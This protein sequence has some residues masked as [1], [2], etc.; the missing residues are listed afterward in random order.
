[1]SR[2]IGPFPRWWYAGTWIFALGLMMSSTL[3]LHAQENRRG[4]AIGKLADELVEALGR[5][6]PDQKNTSVAVR[7]L[8]WDPERLSRLPDDILND[9]DSELF[10]LLRQ[11]F[12]NTPMEV[13]TRRNLMNVYGTRREHRGVANYEQELLEAGADVEVYCTASWTVHDMQNIQLDCQAV[14]LQQRL[15][16]AI[17][18]TATNRATA[19]NSVPIQ[20]HEVFDVV[21]ADLA[22]EIV[23]QLAYSE[24]DLRAVEVVD[25]EF[26]G[27]TRSTALR[28]RMERQLG[29]AVHMRIQRQHQ[30]GTSQ[31]IGAGDQ[32]VKASQ[33]RLH[34]LVTCL[35]AGIDLEV[36]MLEMKDGQTRVGASRA[37]EAVMLPVDILPPGVRCADTVQAP[38][39]IKVSNPWRAYGGSDDLSV[40]VSGL[41]DGDTAAQVLNGSLSRASGSDVGAYAISFGT[42]AVTGAFARKYMLPE[43]STLGSYTIM[44]KEVTVDSAVLTKE[45]D[46]TPGLSGTQLIGGEVSGAVN[47]QSLALSMTG[48]SYADVDVATGITISGPTF[49]LVAGANTN[50]D[51]YALPGSIDLTG[52]ITKK[53]TTFRGTA[54]TRVYDGTDTVSTKI[55][56]TFAPELVGGDVVTISGGTYGSADAG[57]NIPISGAT[58]GG[59]DA[60]NYAVTVGAISGTITARTITA[61][62]VV[63]VVAGTVDGA[64]TANFDTTQATGTGVLASEL[65]DFRAGGL[66]ATGFLTAD[67]GA[68]H[69]SM[70]YTLANSGTFK[71]GN[72]ELGSGVGTGTLPLPPSP[73]QMEPPPQPDETRRPVARH[74]PSRE[75]TSLELRVDATQDDEAYERARAENT[76]ESYAEYLRKFPNGRHETEAWGGVFAAAPTIGVNE[77]RI[78]TLT[79]LLMFEGGPMDVWNLRGEPGTEL[80]LDMVTDEFDAVLSALGDEID[81]IDDDSGGGTNARLEVTLPLSGEVIIIASAFDNSSRGQYVLRTRAA[82]LQP[83]PPQRSRLELGVN[84]ERMGALTDPLTSDDDPMDVWTLRGE[85]GTELH[86]DMVTDEFD[87]VLYA[88]GDEIELW[89]DDSGG[90]TNARLEVTL[91]L[92]GEVIIIAS[93]F[94]S[95]SRGQYV[96]RTRTAAAADDEAYERARAENTMDSYATY[97]RDFPNGRY[98][99]EVLARVTAM[100]PTIGVNEE[101]IEALTD[102]LTSDGYLMDV[103]TLR[104]E[105]GTELHVDMMTDEFDAVLYVMGDEIELWDDDSGGGTNARLEVTLP[106]SG[107]VIIMASAFDNSLRGQYALRTR[108]TAAARD[109]DDYERARAEDTVDSYADYLRKYPNGRHEIEA[110]G[111][112]FAAAPT[113]RANEERQ[114]SLTGD[115]LDPETGLP[116]ELWTLRGEAWTVVSVELVS[117]GFDASLVA[118]DKDRGEMLSDWDLV[119]GSNSGILTYIP[120]SGAVTLMVGASDSASRGD[121]LLRTETLPT[122]GVNEE[123]AGSL[124]GNFIHPGTEAP[125]QVWTLQGEPG[126]RL[127]VEVVTEEFDAYLSAWQIR[128]VEK[129]T[130]DDDLAVGNSARKELTITD[131]GDVTLVVSAKRP[132]AGGVYLLRTRTLAEETRL[133]QLAARD[134]G[135]WEAARSVGTAAAYSGYLTEYP[136]G[137]HADKAQR[138]LPEAKDDEAYE[139]ARAENTMDSYAAYLRDFPNGRYATEAWDGVFAAAPT[140]GVNDERI[141]TLTDLLM[142]EGEPM[143]LWKLRGDAGTELHVDMVTDEF[144]AVLS[145]LADEIELW[146]DDSGGGTNA[147]LE[148]TLP[149]S[150]EVIIIASAF[151][152]SSRGHYVLRTRTAAAKE[153]DEAY[154]RARAENTVES[155][156]EYLTKYPN[157]RHETEAWGGLFATAPIVGVNEERI[158]ALTDRLTSEGYLMDVWTLRGE[159]GTELHIDMVTDEFDAVLNARDNDKIDVLDDDSGSGTNAR[160][161]LT[162]PPSG[163]VIVIAYTYG[164]SGGQYVLRTRTD[165]AARDDEAYDQARAADTSSAYQAYVRRYANGRHV[166]DARRMLAAA[167]RR[168]ENRPGRRFQDCDECPL[169][170]VVPPGS[171]M[172]G[173]PV[174]ER[175]RGRDEGPQHNVTIEYPLAVGVYEITRGEYGSFVASTGHRQPTSCWRWVGEWSRYSGSNWSNPGFRQ[176]DRDPVVCVS[177]EDAMEYVRWLSRVTGEEYRLLSEAEWEYVA[178]GGTNTARYWGVEPE[179]SQCRYA[180]GAD[181]TLR[182][183]DRHQDWEWEITACDDGF[184]R[185]SPGGTY[186]ANGYGLHD[187]LGNVWEWTQNCKSENYEGSPFDGSAWER[188]GCE[189]RVIRG[190][191]WSDTFDLIRS[192]NRGWGNTG[193][194]SHNIGFRVARKINS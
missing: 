75:P 24:S 167:L 54:V 2:A 141:G 16:D 155:Y 1:M 109:D 78:G 30:W 11:E 103:W 89:D 118:W 80:H 161:E 15:A 117:A 31:P 60:G 153:D 46:G 26:T 190:G 52:T 67:A 105:P 149:P 191:S 168:E 32:E 193:Y 107:E 185:T 114:G 187:V 154:E 126:T 164:S 125:V 150:G 175:Q 93:A 134:D 139:R 65:A 70:S 87:A 159:P 19:R 90:G 25:A 172:M 27:D 121:F 69:V 186:E 48:G 66:V 95:S 112:L 61:I 92:S 140:I 128:T 122:I 98:A 142:F 183:K 144:D 49:A 73:L 182:S 99:T 59:V 50:Q 131:D 180:N 174:S 74:S 184:H 160:L 5:T 97:L 10:D 124:T 156:A 72:Y 148:L 22:A 111:G 110:W 88:M 14:Q 146:D 106:P 82:T 115:L 188:D 96:L 176:T 189:R 116:I 108:T 127:Y 123:R 43:A 145:A 41:T 28:G 192:G 169:M 135:A 162:L 179:E 165:A 56:G 20:K 194:H 62:D 33:Y 4:D 113:L 58:V 86:V 157:G 101:R 166:S 163:E 173:T 40:T 147:R 133:T 53:A 71:A 177:W 23:E 17:M 76:V 178:R 39:E 42:L 158:G 57:T 7:P 129:L 35:P 120:A 45:Y 6:I 137:R 181:R 171:Y 13:K 170:V 130:T 138:L 85:P 119:P 152:S 3:L 47:G 18:D 104:G 100:A 34:G 12:L 36:Q 84:E 68:H 79:D 44:P 29:S 38:L 91:P 136:S 64:T 77:E 8:T 9:L 102:P 81:L 37:Y 55:S 83:S 21:I 51:N 143:D 151:D 63:T 132:R 94:D